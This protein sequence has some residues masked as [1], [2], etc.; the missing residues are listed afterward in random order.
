MIKYSFIIPHRN[1]PDL[2]ER[3]VKS[4]PQR[5]DIEIIVVDD[6]SD[7]DKKPTI[8]RE[9][10]IIILLDATQSKGAGRARNVGMRRA[11]G[12]WLL[13]ADADDFYKKG[14]LNFLDDLVN[15]KNDAIY[16]S[17]DSVKSD[18]LEP[19]MRTRSL[20]LAIKEFDGSE[21][22]ASLIK[23]KHHTPWNK[24]VSADF[25]LKYG[26]QFEEVEQGNDTMFSYMVG[27]FA[28]NIKV[29]PMDLYTYTYN[30]NSITTREKNMA[31]YHCGVLN[32]FKQA[33]FLRFVGKPEYALSPIQYLARC[34]RQY[35]FEGLM[36]IVYIMFTS[37]KEI[38]LQSTKYIKIVQ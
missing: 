25:I 7:E 33:K 21:Q 13:F 9:G 3:C 22:A 36:K 5:D 29:I 32:Y 26:I 18:T 27:Y 6:N 34:Y 20:Q 38:R 31:H 17:A 24:M 8:S 16:F 2:L 10:V 14:F 28:K 35:G 11:Q 1:T 15:S 23:Y 30:E 19:Y 12:K 4:I 37:Q